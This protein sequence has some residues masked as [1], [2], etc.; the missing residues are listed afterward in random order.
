MTR[1]KPELNAAK[2]DGK[3][4]PQSGGLYLIRKILFLVLL[5]MAAGIAVVFVFGALYIKEISEELPT[6]SQIL[7]HKE[8]VASTVYDRDNEIIA[9]LFTENRRPVQLKDISPWILKCTLAAEDSSFYQHGG[10]RVTAIGRA[11]MVD[12]LHRG[13]RQGGST[14][15]QQLARNLFLSQEKTI[16]RKAKEIMLA[17]RMEQLFSKDKI[18]EMYLNTIY[19][20]HGAWGIETA[21]KTY[22]GK[23]S[24]NLTL[25]ESAVI[26]GLIAAPERYSP[27]N[28]INNAKKRQGYVLGR[29]VD[30]GWIDS[31]TKEKAYI[32]EINLKHV[33]NKV[34]EFNKA[35]YFISHLLINHLLPTYGADLVYSGGMEIYTTIDLDLQEKADNAIKMLKSQ[36]A[37]VALD[38]LTGEVLALTGGKDFSTSKFNRVTQAYRQPGSAFKPFVFAAALEKGIMPTDHFLDAPLSYDVPGEEKTWEPGNYGQKFHG[39]VTVLDALIHSYNT[40]AVRMAD[41]TGVSNIIKMARST[42][43]TSSH[44]PHDLSIALGTASVTPL[45][46]AT[47][48]ST[49]ANGG[50]VVSP[51][52]IREIRSGNGDV[53][54]FHKPEIREGISPVTATVIR[55]LMEDAVRAGTGRNALI[56]GWETFGK[57][58]TTNEYSDAWFAGGVPG[59]VTIVYA[60]NDDHK[61]LGRNATGSAIAVPVWKSFMSE[62]VKVLH[63]PQAF[64]IPQGLAVEAVRVCRQTGF[65]AAPGCSA[66]TLLLPAGSTP[67][68]TCPIHGGD[69]FACQND[70]LAP[71]LYLL[72]QDEEHYYTY[73]KFPDGDI[74]FS[75]AGSDIEVKVSSTVEEKSQ[76]SHKP[77]QKSVIPV[78]E[79]DP[80]K[81]DPS[82]AQTI[83]E[84]YQDLLKQYGITN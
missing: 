13:A 16:K 48:F 36:G 60:G 40:V 38:P 47:A 66:A 46:M 72:P 9:R 23:E 50:H 71:R 2:R 83:E 74:P 69:I 30:L 26:A 37:L 18:L 82:P 76:L 70:S 49:F 79:Q 29:L 78:G 25:S 12:I 73:A 52:M 35:P 15:T 65:L 84:R 44:L 24:R 53:L 67:T 58:G 3:Q 77:A 4:P 64:D 22:F 39:E 19:F 28:N 34:T 43:I 11:L 54:E 5:V 1:K 81:D 57:T 31:E 20:G 32:E 33:P 45:E 27:L 51:L 55:S 7:A 14:I 6:T 10:I 59:L 80:Y 21:A 17:I 41:I 62:A 8:N 68:T 63:L 56:P 42:G 75:L 61:A